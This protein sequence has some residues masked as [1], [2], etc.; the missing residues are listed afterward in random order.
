MS[1]KLQSLVSLIDSLSLK[2]AKGRLARYLCSLLPVDGKAPVAVDL[3]MSKTLLSQH[4]GIKMETLSRTFRVLVKDGTLGS[5]KQG[6]IEILDIE[7]IQH[8]AG[9]D[10]K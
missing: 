8:A 2:D 4:L 6:H 7:A 5:I 1:K 10:L 3:P 9:D